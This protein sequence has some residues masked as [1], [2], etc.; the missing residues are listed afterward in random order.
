MSAVNLRPFSV[1]LILAATI[2]STAF[3][4]MRPPAGQ[5]CPPGAYV[6]GFDL[7]GNILCSE[8]V[9]EVD[10]TAEKAVG[11]SQGQPG[12]VE[13]ESAAAQG[14]ATATAS[15]VAGTSTPVPAA[16]AD[17]P[18][19]IT[20]VEPWS[21]V[22]GKRALDVVITGSGFTSESSVVFNGQRHDATVNNAG[23]ELRVTLNTRGLAIGQYPIKVVNG[24]GSEAS[25]KRAVVV[26]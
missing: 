14:G 16:P 1:V 26:Y 24:S 12:A 18:P 20:G 7:E 13:P 17:A 25:L 10:A 9:H 19:V 8:P 22:Y 2:Q 23:T 6:T 3:A 15:A 4:D 5:Q 21:V 11:A